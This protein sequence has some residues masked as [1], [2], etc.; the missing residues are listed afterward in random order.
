MNGDAGIQTAVTT[1]TATA[2]TATTQT[3]ITPTATTTDTTDTTNT[4]DTTDTTT[5]TESD[6]ITGV[7]VG[8]EI[9]QQLATGKKLFCSCA[10]LEPDS[11]TTSFERRLRPSSGEMGKHDAAAIFE[12]TK[13]KTIKYY[14]N[15]N[16]SCLVE[17]DEEPPHE[18]DVDAK[19]IALLIASA[20]NSRIYT[21]LHTMRKTVVDGS[22]TAGFQRTILVSQGGSFSILNGKQRQTIGVQSICLE[23]DAAKK[24]DTKNDH[25]S[26]N[27]IKQDIK[28]D[29]KK[30]GLERLGVPLVEIATEPFPVS[31]FNTV[32]IVALTLGRILRST[33]MVTRGLGSIRQDVNVSIANGNGIVVEVKGVQQLDQI[34]N[35]VK[36]EAQRQNGLLEISKKLQKCG[37]VHNPSKDIV[38]VTDVFRDSESKII[39][40]AL[41]QEKQQQ[42]SPQQKQQDNHI[43]AVAFRGAKGIF[44]Y[45][46]YKD[47]R[48]G[49]EIAQLVKLFGIGGIFHSDELPAYGI[50][51]KDVQNV[52]ELLNIDQHNC[53][54]FFML[55]APHAKTDA[56][57]NQII[58]RVQQI[59]QNGIP[60]DTRYATIDGKTVFQRPRPGAARMYP[61][62]DIQT[63]PITQNEI[64]YAKSNIPKPWDESIQNLQSA[65]GINQ[66]LAE[67]LWDSTRLELFEEIAA[68]ISNNDNINNKHDTDTVQ[69]K[70][71]T[72]PTF[73]ASV[74][75]STITN[76]ERQNDTDSNLLSD[77]MIRETFG[78]LYK[79]EITKESIEIIFQ[80][81]MTKKSKTIA[82]AIKSA[83]IQN[84]SKEELAHTI[85]Q[86]IQDNKDMIKNQ[87]T[88][89]AKPLM[90]IAMKKLRGKAPGQTIN[91]LVVDSIK[92]ILDK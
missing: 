55:V 72:T 57:I 25:N 59:A 50:T 2:T 71:Q 82:D 49:K 42:Q 29:I 33:R 41:K 53:D 66:Q 78:L 80:K 6:N 91:E 21:E 89:A 8:L 7:K 31:D 26:N 74:L 17:Q 44:G 13:A 56:I 5:T 24:I 86:I 37:W 47:V 38:D 28:Q 68:G 32:K 88:R 67:Q 48:L 40:K 34:E 12:G 3:T 10:P 65:Y 76:L 85:N 83:S 16:S 90:G 20:L 30:Y 35:V 70:N 51:S 63:I 11:Y 75:C 39:Q 92:N 4:N 9:H 81:I 64:N 61:E 43:I 69:N 84:I 23:E 27:H 36:Y 54:A 73:V 15:Y 87:G 60:A 22:N 14:A 1:A 77:D 18:L 58:H 79:K 52:S 46:P 45:T 62:T 19:K